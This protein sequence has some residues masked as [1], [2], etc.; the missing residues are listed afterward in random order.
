MPPSELTTVLMMIVKIAAAMVS[1]TLALVTAGW[2]FARFIFEP[3]FARAI[4]KGVEEALGPFTQRLT[5]VEREV[6]EQGSDIDRLQD[7]QDHNEQA[8]KT[9]MGDLRSGLKE[10]ADT[11]RE[12]AGVQADQ[13]ASI[14]SI[15]GAMGQLTPP[16]PRRKRPC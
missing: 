10:I 11:I 3:R 9:L 2:A 4:E 16:R 1:L 14:A 8:V 12:V 7:A 15:Q 13:A 5:H 6:V